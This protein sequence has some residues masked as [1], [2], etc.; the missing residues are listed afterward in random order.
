[1]VKRAVAALLSVR[2]HELG[3]VLDELVSFVQL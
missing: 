1:M 3:L 2:F